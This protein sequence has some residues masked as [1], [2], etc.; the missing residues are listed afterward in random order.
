MKGSGED[1]KSSAHSLHHLPQ[2]PPRIS[3]GLRH[4]YRHPR[5]KTASAVSRLEVGGSVR[6]L[7]G[8]AQ[9]V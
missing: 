3:G 4:R 6:D 8:N 7:P 1:F 5:G 9:C 2:L